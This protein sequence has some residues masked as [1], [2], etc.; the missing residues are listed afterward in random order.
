MVS[1]V[2][3]KI[4]YDYFNN[5]EEYTNYLIRYIHQNYGYHTTP[6]F[7]EKSGKL[8]VENLS[9]NKRKKIVVKKR[10][11]KYLL[12]NGTKREILVEKKVNH[13][14]K[15]TLDNRQVVIDKKES[16]KVSYDTAKI[17]GLSSKNEK[18]EYKDNEI[19]SKER[20]DKKNDIN[21]IVPP[22]IDNRYDI[23]Q[24]IKNNRRR[25]L[26]DPK[27]Y[28]LPDNVDEY[29]REVREYY[30]TH[31]KAKLNWKDVIYFG[32]MDVFFSIGV[33]IILSE[34]DPG[35]L[36]YAIFLVFFIFSLH[37][38]YSLISVVAFGKIPD[39]YAISDAKK[40]YLNSEEYTRIKKYKR[41]LYDAKM[42][43]RSTWEAMSG[44]EFECAVANVYRKMGYRTELC[45]Q[46]GDGGIDIKL[47][48]DGEII[49][50]QCKAHKRKVSPHVARDFYGTMKAHNYKEGII[51]SLNGFSKN[52]VDFTRDLNE[53]IELV[54]I[55]TLLD[56]NE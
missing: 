39:K 33:G 16:A 3:R 49:P 6:I 38:V 36:I 40:E 4:I 19:K 46:G 31:T 22:P 21:M 42:R 54:D 37:W 13:N 43:L 25:Y 23:S 41:A 20:G 32:G 17:Q 44:R 51:V 11:N 12:I 18:N 30:R 10:I 7:T 1:K 27:E 29:E 9:E 14:R 52:T 56:M 24:E 34:L 8:I 53:R 26:V 50:V 15:D 28:G 5:N 2:A 35:T 48:K 55:D 45:K 47:Y